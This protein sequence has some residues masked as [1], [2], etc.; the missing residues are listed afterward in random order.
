MLTKSRVFRHRPALSRVVLNIRLF[1]LSAFL[2][3]LA[4]TL[5]ANGTIFGPWTIRGTGRPV[6]EKRTF[7]VNDRSGR[8]VLRVKNADLINGLFVVNDPIVLHQ[9]DLTSVGSALTVG[10]RLQLHS[11]PYSSDP[12]ARRGVLRS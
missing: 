5:S 11:R 6:V 1:T 12:N 9:R 4:V 3:I 8:F 10:L 2:S 7:R